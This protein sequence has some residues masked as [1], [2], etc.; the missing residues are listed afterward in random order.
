MPLCLRGPSS[1][2]SPCTSRSEFVQPAPLSSHECP[3]LLD[4]AP[5]CPSPSHR[6]LDKFPGTEMAKFAG[7][8]QQNMRRTKQREHPPSRNEIIACLV[9]GAPAPSAVSCCHGDILLLQGCRE[10]KAVVY[11]Y[12]GA[13]CNITINSATTAQDV[14]PHTLAT[15]IVCGRL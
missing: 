6:V 13:E 1:A 3:L 15:V 4:P 5:H 8:C 11:T 7:Y 2:T 9:S 12:G 14:R 10:T